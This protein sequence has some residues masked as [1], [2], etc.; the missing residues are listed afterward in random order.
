MITSRS[1]GRPADFLVSLQHNLFH[2]FALAHF[3]RQALIRTR[4]AIVNVGSKVA[5]TGQGRTSGYAAAKGAILALT[6]E[7]AVA[8]AP[9]EVRVNCVVP[10]ECDTPLYQRWFDLQPDPV[11]CACDDRASGS[12]RTAAH[13]A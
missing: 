2:V 6:R 3:A 12:A 10:A 4:G 9:H 8:L 5:V 13:R 11:D 1:I 7:W